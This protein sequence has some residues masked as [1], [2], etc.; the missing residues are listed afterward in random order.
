VRRADP[1]RAVARRL[2][3]T[4]ALALKGDTDAAETLWLA[5]ESLA[6][7][8]ATLTDLQKRQHLRNYGILRA[9]L[10]RL[11]H[12]LK[13][14]LERRE[15]EALEAVYH[16]ADQA[17]RLLKTTAASDPEFV[18]GFAERCDF[19]PVMMGTKEMYHEAAD[20][21]LRKIRVGQKSVLPTTSNTRIEGTDRWTELAVML[22]TDII[23]FRGL[24]VNFGKG[25]KSSSPFEQKIE[26]D[27]LSKARRFPGVLKLRTPL[28][29][30]TRSAWHIAAMAALQSTESALIVARARASTPLP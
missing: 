7:S 20:E 8:L 24:L 4:Y 1:Q 6:C 30:E 3:A 26:N 23:L 29:P 16:L 5:F 28:S 19:W 2:R 9:V 10:M 12:Q 14:G 27:L 17:C 22:I 18:A 21:Y 25:T 15:N 13:T 11:L